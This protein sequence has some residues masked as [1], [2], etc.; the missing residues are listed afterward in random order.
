MEPGGSMPHSQGLFNNNMTEKQNREHIG[1][2]FVALA[3]DS[4]SIPTTM[5]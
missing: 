2:W 5:L 4:K 1:G 3:Q